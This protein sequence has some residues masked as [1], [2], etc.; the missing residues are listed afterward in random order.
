[1]ATTRTPSSLRAEWLSARAFL[2]SRRLRPVVPFAAAALVLAFV[3]VYAVRGPL[4]PENPVA[5]ETDRMAGATE[6]DTVLLGAKMVAAQVTLAT[7]DSMLRALQPPSSRSGTAGA[8]PA[9]VLSP[10]QQRTRDSLRALLTQLDG[11]LDRS[12]KAPLPASYRTLATTHALRTLGGI[13]VLV[14]TL[15][16]LERTRMALD[17]A[18]APQSEFAQLSQRANAIGRTL[19][20]IGQERRSELLQQVTAIGAAPDPAARRVAPS[21]DT[22]AAR[23]G[24]DSARAQVRRA[25]SLLRDARVWH[26]AA[27]ARADSTAHAQAARILGVSPVVVAF[28]I[29]VLVAVAGFTLAVFVEVR[30]PTIAHAREVERIT[31]LPVLAVA[32]GF[33]VPREG[34]ARLQPGTGVDPVHMVYLAMTASGARERIVCITGD[35]P[36]LTVAVAGRLAASAAADERATLLVDLAAGVPS[37]STY[38]GW[39]DEPGFTDAIAGVRLWREVAR[40]VGASEGITMD[41]VPVGGPRQDTEVSVQDAEARAEFAAFLAEYDFSIF[42]APTPAALR[43]AEVMVGGSPVILVVRTARTRLDTLRS[44]VQGMRGESVNVLGTLLIG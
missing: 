11:A 13:S 28:A 37:V 3:V 40:S 17:P 10:D 35:D 22:A 1:M 33:H 19:Q 4:A 44:L 6:R 16:L 18:A 15:E 25:D 26:V 41:V 20:S 7:R 32:T 14:D 2:A 5:V 21:A 42:V 9:P 23:A 29:V 31:G 27:R 12:A 39:R 24:R 38:F 30:T 36:S 8:A 34:R 43:L